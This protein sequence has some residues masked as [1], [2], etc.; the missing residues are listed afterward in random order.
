L[1]SFSQMAQEW[2]GFFSAMAQVS[3]G[4][5]GLVFVALTFNSKALGVGGDPALGTLAR[6]TFSDFLILLVVSMLMLAPHVPGWEIGLMLLILGAVTTLRVLVTLPR[7]RRQA[8]ASS[9]GWSVAGRFLLS[10]VGRAM[11]GVAGYELLIGNPNSDVA[12][13]ALLSGAMMLVIS[14]CRSA[15]L[16]VLQEAK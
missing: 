15:W 9:G 8:V 12:G 13:S 14:G 4:L 3:G 16:L 7:S 2:A 6:Q 1:D 5:V 11:L 10:A